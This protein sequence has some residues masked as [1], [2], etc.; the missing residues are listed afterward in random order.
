MAEELA[1]LTGSWFVATGEEGLRAFSRD[2]LAWTHD[3]TDREGV[4]LH[5]ACFA[6]G[7]CVAAG[8]YGGE[9][10][11][12]STGDGVRWTQ[13]KPEGRPYVSQ[14]TIL[15]AEGGKFHAVMCEDGDPPGELASI[16]GLTWEPRRPLVADRQNMK[17]DAA[18]RRIALGGG[19]AVI[20]GD[21]GAR[22]VREGKAPQFTAL[23]GIPARDTLVDITFGNGVFVG[24]GMHGLR[25]RSEDG[26]TWTDRTVGEEGEHINAMIWDGAQFVGLGQ[27]GTYL[28]PD[29]RNWRREP[30]QNAPTIA[31]FGNGVFLGALWPGKLLRSTDGMRW[32]QV[33]EFSHHVLGLA[34]GRL[35]P[36]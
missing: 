13:S 3:Q 1:P 18:L 15:Y 8:K 33:H 22:L 9:R 36:G 23:P 12:F 21:Y 4:L 24:A 20:V 6:N 29:G 19:R 32:E 7:R 30:N 26:I 25:M 16:D 31:T 27:G 5:Q 28:S 17:R 14:L 10:I 2:G 34:H 11:A 35:G